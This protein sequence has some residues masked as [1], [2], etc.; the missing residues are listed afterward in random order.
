MRQNHLLLV[1]CIYIFAASIAFAVDEEYPK[2]PDAQLTPGVLC[3]SPDELRYAEKVPY[4]NRNVS[5]GLKW[6]VINRYTKKFKFTINANNRTEFKIDHYIP[7][8]MGGANSIDNLWPQHSSIYEVTDS[9][10]K[11]LCEAMSEGK[12]SQA[13]AIEEVKMGK[14]NLD[15]V[16]G[17][18]REI[19]LLLGK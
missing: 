11:T 19:N 13:K 8:C 16:P 4:C 10:E 14:A 7:L 17:I 12:M 1:A 2:S 15:A 5:T 18:I 6:A 9:L 3:T